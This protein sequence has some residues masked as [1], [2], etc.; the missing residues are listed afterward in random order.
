MYCSRLRCTSTPGALQES[1]GSCNRTPMPRCGPCQGRRVASLQ[2]VYGQGIVC[3]AEPKQ[4]DMN[5]LNVVD[6]QMP[7]RMLLVIRLEEYAVP[8]SA[9][10][11][12]ETP[13]WW[14]VDQ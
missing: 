7:A 1:D 8:V 10:E 6:E 4:R 3:R 2:L 13:C 5:D 12:H 9:V 11:T 14:N